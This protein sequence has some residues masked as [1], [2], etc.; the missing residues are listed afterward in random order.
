MPSY[1]LVKY[2]RR[3]RRRLHTTSMV[4]NSN[5]FPLDASFQITDRRLASRYPERS[6][7]CGYVCAV[8]VPKPKRTVSH[9]YTVDWMK[10]V[11]R[12]YLCISL[13]VNAC[14][15]FQS[16]HWEKSILWYIVMLWLVK[17]RYAHMQCLDFIVIVCVHTSNGNSSGFRQNQPNDNSWFNLSSIGHLYTLLILWSVKYG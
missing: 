5:L 10:V 7:R 4:S 11:L 16:R 14:D 15:Q 2:C 8:E 13:L 12:K 6:G 3:R 17:I 1:R 9:I